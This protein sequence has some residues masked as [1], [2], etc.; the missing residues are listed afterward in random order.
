MG[1]WQPQLQTPS[2]PNLREHLSTS[3]YWNAPCQSFH[4]DSP[5]L[6]S[7]WCPPPA[8]VRKHGNRTSTEAPSNNNRMGKA[9]GVGSKDSPTNCTRKYMYL[10]ICMYKLMYVLLRAKRMC[11]PRPLGSIH[12]EAKKRGRREDFGHWGS[13]S[14]FMLGSWVLDRT[15]PQTRNPKT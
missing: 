11:C 14:F 10:N 2:I 15:P 7:Y 8:K 6:A 4:A 3:T 12:R 1:Q 13:C 9:F 5:L